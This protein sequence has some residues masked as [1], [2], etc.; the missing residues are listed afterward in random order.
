MFSIAK[1][2]TSGVVAAAVV[3]GTLAVYPF[4]NGDKVNAAEYEAA[5]AVNFSSILGDAV[6][7]G[8]VANSYEQNKHTETTYAVKKYNNLSGDV[9]EVDYIT[10]QTAHFMMGEFVK[11]DTDPNNHLITFGQKQTALYYYFVGSKQ[12]M[13]GFTGPVNT[14]DS[15]S[16]NFKTQ[17]PFNTEGKAVFDWSVSDDVNTY[18][19]GVLDKATNS[20]SEISSRASDSNYCV[21]D[22]CIELNSNNKTLT[23]NLVNSP[24]YNFENRVVYVNVTAEMLPA[25]AQ[26][27]GVRIIKPSSTIVVF[28]IESTVKGIT[29]KSDT[30]TTAD[31]GIHLNTIK[32]TADGVDVYSTSGS[33]G[34]NKNNKG[35]TNKQVNDEICEKIIW[36]IEGNRNVE[37]DNTAGTFLITDSGS[38]VNVSGSCAGWVVAGG[39][40]Q[41]NAEW[42]YIY[43]GG[44]QQP[45]K[46]KKNQMHF[47][48]RK[49][50]TDA[51]SSSMTEDKSIVS[52][53]GDYSFELY[54]TDST[55]NTEKLSPIGSGSTQSTNYVD[56]PSIQFYTDA[57]EAQNNNASDY[58]VANTEHFFFVVKEQ[59]AGTIN[60]NIENSTGYINIELVVT[61]TNNNLSYSLSY[62]TYAPDTAN[63]GFIECKSVQN[64]TMY[65]VKGDLGDFFNRKIVP[66]Y[67]KV[68]KSVTGNVV[69]SSLVI[70]VK[71]GNT[72]VEEYSVANGTL[73]YNSNTKLYEASSVLMVDSSKTYTVEE[74][75][76]TLDG[77]TCVSSY[78]INNGT[79]QN[80]NSVTVNSISTD[81]NEPTLVAFT[82]EYTRITGSLTIDKNLTGVSGNSDKAF[83]FTVAVGNNEGYIQQDGTI[84]NQAYEFSVTPSTDCVITIDYSAFGKSL[85]VIESET[86]RE[87]QGYAFKDVTYTDNGAVISNNSGSKT[88]TVDNEYYLSGDI[89]LT[90]TI[91]EGL[92]QKQLDGISFNI[93]DGNTVVWSGSLSDSNVFSFVENSNGNDKYIATITGLD[94]NKTYEIEE[95]ITDASIS[96]IY[97]VKTYSMINLPGN[98]SM[99]SR[100]LTISGSNNK[101]WTD[102]LPVAFQNTYDRHATLTVNKVVTGN[103]SM[104][105]HDFEFCIVVGDNEGYIQIDGTCDDHKE[106]FFVRN[107]S[108]FPI[109]IDPEVFG[110]KLTVEEVVDDDEQ[111]AGYYLSTTYVGN[112]VVF[113]D[114]RDQKSVTITNSYNESGTLTFTKTF[115]GDV[116]EAEAKGDNLYFVVQNTT[117]GQYLSAAGALV[118]IADAANAPHITLA[119]L[120]HTD[121]TMVWSKSFN[122]TEGEYSIVEHNEEIYVNGG[123][124]PYT[125]DNATST[126]T[127]STN[128]TS[129]V[130]GSLELTNNYKK[131]EPGPT[132]TGTLEITKSFQGI[133]DS[134]ISS[135]GTIEFSIT[136]DNGYTNTITYA[137]FSGGVWSASVPVGKY[138]VVEV[139]NGGTTTYEFVSVA[140][141]G[142]DGDTSPEIVIAEDG[143]AKADFTNTYKDNSPVSTLSLVINKNIEG[144]TLSQASQLDPISFTITG[145][146]EF[147]SNTGTMNVEYSQF[148]NGTWSIENVPAGEYTVEE[149]SSGATSVYSLADTTVN[150]ASGSSA[151]IDSANAVDNKMV[152]TFVNT[153]NDNTPPAPTTGSLTIVTVVEGGSS[154]ADNKTFTF[155][156]KEP[157]GNERTVTIQGEG[158]LTI[159]DLVPGTYIVTE[160][161]P[162]AEIKDYDL[163]I[164]GSGKEITVVAGQDS[165]STITNTYKLSNPI[166]P[167][168]VTGSISFSKTFG[169]DVT[170][171]EAA[172]CG[173]YFVITN[174]AGEYLD[175]DGNISSDEVRI[176]LKDMDHTDGTLVWSKTINDVP[177]DTYYVTEHNEVIYINGG[178][179]P[180]TFEK[181][182]SVTT[183]HTTLWNTSE[184]GYF[185]LENYYTHPGFDVTIS[186]EDIAGK[187]IAQAQLKFKSLD[188]YDLSKVV[189]TQ[190]GVPVQF[191][192]SDN[193]TAITFTTIEGYPS[194]IQGLFSGRYELE[195][196]V[197]PEAYLTAEKIV[198][199]LN[200]DGTITD[201]EGKIS[202]YGSPVVMIDQADPYYDT[203]VISANRTP[204]PIPATGEKSNFIALVGIALVGLCSAALAGL[205]VYR[206]KRN[207]F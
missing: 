138:T 182:T 109:D 116:T 131:P 29:V 8:I 102:R 30:N 85:T 134:Q 124:T 155:I 201:G 60:G 190:N 167:Q 147:N 23:I 27:E 6:D 163:D 151:T 92:T 66:G 22:N 111:V 58:Y 7:F 145:P 107:N 83:K 89:V 24:D 123:S 65:G 56:L 70:Q 161:K 205:G 177:F 54:K 101:P 176:T 193:N 121:G 77:Y 53:A 11:H 52:N 71:D 127:D 96:G 86:G 122:V 43:T 67:I 153:Y 47:S 196:T 1:R 115:G 5:S 139:S 95:V 114:P 32:V 117:T 35:N 128:V 137:D 82:N 149:T 81:P 79:S 78:K 108:S 112:E 172:G 51:Y 20:S 33:M 31:D 152:F 41:N 165:T 159:T 119:D 98:R 50:F 132:P 106:I 19:Q 80:S 13:E 143:T 28:N 100:R 120:D 42:H 64:E 150:G 40:I 26:S 206:K 198:F 142:V 113:N 88:V 72:V 148:S 179:V 130:R 93:Y 166:P 44:S 135:L 191:T 18:I 156:V 62:K 187:E 173:L 68:T 184:D 9:N 194:I 39:T 38:H 168:P 17:Y 91:T 25:L 118:T 34:E 200:N 164:D 15:I 162:E 69:P 55:Y 45:P 157:S 146:A 141:N 49:A 197:T 192:L 90:K 195:E 104:S 178:K 73:V 2:I 125:F 126:T 36:N 59:N 171:A 75:G 188:G 203:E 133:T 3:L 174:E 170:E 186:K 183:D 16:G 21:P 4:Q 57:T 14:G 204:N 140:V 129:A 180:Y 136:G 160:S 94:R 76:Y 84:G 185:D 202:A 63:G 87:I 189:V 158:S 181:T 74:T 154:E 12:V 199:V 48:L 97:R 61:N 175:L 37:L 103:S 99:E 105:D 46:D 10:S 144:I 207:E 110:K 169:G